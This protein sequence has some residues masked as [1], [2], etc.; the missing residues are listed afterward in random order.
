MFDIFTDSPFLF[1]TFSHGWEVLCVSL[2]VCFSSNVTCKFQ[3]GGFFLL[4]TIYGLELLFVYLFLD[5]IPTEF[6]EVALRPSHLFV[7][8]WLE[9]EVF[10]LLI[11]VMWM[12]LGNVKKK[13][14][15][16]NAWWKIKHSP[17]PLKRARK[18][19]ITQRYESWNKTGGLQVFYRSE[20]EFLQTSGRE[21]SVRVISGYFDLYELW[22]QDPGLQAHGYGAG[23]SP[24][25]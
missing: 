7:R 15:K 2:K 4:T 11:S 25:W 1:K 16:E 6:Q 9:K 22:F 24:L 5:M 3:G 12:F 17:F 13:K 14:L 8:S 20:E 23:S 10:V 21:G 18:I 19:L